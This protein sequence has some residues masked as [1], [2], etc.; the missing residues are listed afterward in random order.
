MSP[1]SKIDLSAYAYLAAGEQQRFNHEDCPAGRDTRRRLY[2]K[3]TEDDRKLLG[4]CHNCGLKAVMTPTTSYSHRRSM[5]STALRAAKPVTLPTD[6]ETEPAKWP[7]EMVGWLFRTGLGFEEAKKF[8]VGYSGYYGRAILPVWNSGELRGFQTRH[9]HALDTGPKYR[10]YCIKP[11][12]RGLYTPAIK[13]DKIVVCEDLFSAWKCGHIE[14]GFAMC[15]SDLKAAELL[16]LSLNGYNHVIIWLDNDQPHIRKKARLL[17]KKA[18]LFFPKV[19]A[20]LDKSEP[21]HLSLT[22]IT[23]VLRAKGC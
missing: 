7:P 9:I 15:R 21:K 1:A 2:V 3:R 17:A 8:G 18:A 16:E 4:Y 23:E 10:T 19:D 6:L 22:E 12:L 5:P 20:V 13:P 11:P 14:A